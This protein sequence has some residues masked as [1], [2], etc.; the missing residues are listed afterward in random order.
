MKSECFFFLQNWPALEWEISFLWRWDYVKKKVFALWILVISKKCNQQNNSIYL[1]SNGIS[2][3]YTN[4]LIDYGDAKC[5]GKY[6]QFLYNT[7]LSENYDKYH[8]KF[9]SKIYIFFDF[10]CGFFFCSSIN[11]VKSWKCPFMAPA[12]RQGLIKIFINYYN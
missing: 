2:K 10:K 5:L 7:N 1:F 6:I 9:F 12:K 4:L 3:P 8:K 11:C